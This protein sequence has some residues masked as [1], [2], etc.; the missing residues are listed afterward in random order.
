[1]KP[2]AP[3]RVETDWAPE[4]TPTSPRCLWW[5]EKI[6]G[7]WKRNRRLKTMGYEEAAAYF[8]VYNGEY[9]SILWPLLQELDA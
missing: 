4:G 9:V 3:P 8:G 5:I 7:G 1:M 2:A 6:R